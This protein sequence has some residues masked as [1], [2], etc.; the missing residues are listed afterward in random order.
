VTSSP[1]CSILSG[2]S[3]ISF[4]SQFAH[5]KLYNCG[6]CCRSMSELG[7]TGIH[8][9]VVDVAGRECRN[10]TIR[11]MVIGYSADNPEALAVFRIKQQPCLDTRHVLVQDFAGTRLSKYHVSYNRPVC[12]LF[13]D[14]PH[15]TLR[16]CRST[17][18]N[19]KIRSVSESDAV[20]AD[21]E[22]VKSAPCSKTDLEKIY[23]Q[24]GTYGKPLA[25]VG[26]GVAV[27]ANPHFTFAQMCCLGWGHI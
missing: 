6:I 3:A 12:M 22:A 16:C 10:F 8:F 20:V 13:M 1:I 25:N 17:N 24:R 21:V 26:K 23:M 18:P 9:D 5:N 27:P 7:R 14:I 11:I 4:A 19:A 15:L 2:H